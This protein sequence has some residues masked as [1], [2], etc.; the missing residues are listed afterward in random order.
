MNRKWEFVGEVDK[1]ARRWQ[2]C[3]RI[4][5]VTPRAKF[6]ATYPRGS[7]SSYLWKVTENGQEQYA[8]S[9]CAYAR[10]RVLVCTFYLF[11]STDVKKIAKISN[12]TKTVSIAKH[13]FYP[14][15][16]QIQ[17]P[18]CKEILYCAE[19]VS[20]TNFVMLRISNPCPHASMFA[21]KN[22]KTDKYDV[23]FQKTENV[24]I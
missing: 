4:W 18:F 17:C 14:Q 2:E 13:V 15:Q 6:T 19:E 20:F 16:K 8:L 22:L 1:P 23:L 12:I 5:G 24:V 3:F 9:S 21:G 10:G 7:K 11:T